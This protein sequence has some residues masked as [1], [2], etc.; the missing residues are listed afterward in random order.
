MG[1]CWTLRCA[2]GLT[3]FQAGMGT[4][5]LHFNPL[6]QL[7]SHSLLQLCQ[8]QEAGGRHPRV[9]AARG[10]GEGACCGLIQGRGVEACCA[11]CLSRAHACLVVQSACVP[12]AGQAAVEGLLFAWWRQAAEASCAPNSFPLPFLEHEQMFCLS[13]NRRSS[14]S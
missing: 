12:W 9:R 3:V 13:S 4:S 11:G 7:S 6:T 2:L 5:W 10:R 1:L 8:L 14:P